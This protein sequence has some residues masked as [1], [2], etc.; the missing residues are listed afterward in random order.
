M[1]NTFVLDVSGSM[2]HVI[3]L[4]KEVMAFIGKR[5]PQDY[6]GIV[7]FESV[8]EDLFPMKKLDTKDNFQEYQAKVSGL[9]HKGCTDLCSGVMK[10]LENL[11][12]LPPE[13]PS[14]RRNL[15]IL[16]DGVT[17][18]GLVQTLAIEAKISSHPMISRTNIHPMAL[19]TQVNADLLQSLAVAHNGK[20]YYI[21]NKDEIREQF[22]DCLGSMMGTVIHGCELTV[23]TATN[24]VSDLSRLVHV[25]H[26]DT[27]ITYP[28]GPLFADETKNILFEIREVTAS[29]VVT[30]SLKFTGVGGEH[31]AEHKALLKVEGSEFLHENPLISHHLLRIGVAKLINHLASADYRISDLLMSGLQNLRQRI[32]DEKWDNT[33]LGIQLMQDIDAVLRTRY[34]PCQG[35]LYR[36]VSHGL[37]VQRQSSVSHMAPSRTEP[38]LRAPAFPPPLFPY[39]PLRRQ[40]AMGKAGMKKAVRFDSLLSNVPAPCRPIRQPRR[41]RGRK[42]SLSPQ[43]DAKISLSPIRRSVSDTTPTHHQRDAQDSPPPLSL[44]SSALPILPPPLSA[45]K[46]AHTRTAPPLYTT[47]LQRTVS[48]TFKTLDD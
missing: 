26:D 44:S 39:P 48:K 13:S 32:E 35:I 14:E 41:K 2:A 30:V 37:S 17:N 7:T 9:E 31:T 34:L 22:G 42:R 18:T 33:P 8:V 24:A 36:A 40:D 3:P 46:P 45:P 12:H 6:T 28:I 21:N 43:P 47:F 29:T 20:L 11:W 10:G 19:G 4:L 27:S 38:L 15:I 16:T 5:C 1:K 25:R 23:S